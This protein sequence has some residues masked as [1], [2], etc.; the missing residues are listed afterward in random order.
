MGHSLDWHFLS[1]EV[2][3]FLYVREAQKPGCE[4]SFCSRIC[5]GG[6][7]LAVCWGLICK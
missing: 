3:N 4:H 1:F 2:H 7:E 5:E 6:S